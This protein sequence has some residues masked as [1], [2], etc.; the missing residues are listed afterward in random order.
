[1]K[2]IILTIFLFVCSVSF[3][4][5]KDNIGLFSEEEAVTVNEAIEKLEKEKEIK[6]YL[7]TVIGEESFQIEN[8]QKTFII[9]YQKIG[10]NVVVTELKFTEDLRMGD[11]SQ[12]IDLIL[13][14]LKEQ[15]FEKNYVG[16]T[17]ALLE[18]VGNFITLDQKDENNEEETFSEDSAGTKKS[19]LR[20]VFSKNP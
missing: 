16:Y 14:A 1:M 20:R 3:G 4:E 13:D 18:Q 2:K 11:K 12:E 5:L 8:P 15:L 6:I 10:K 19:F 9:T 17:T 7:N